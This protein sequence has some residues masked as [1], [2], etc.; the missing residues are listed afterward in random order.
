M[1]GSMNSYVAEGTNSFPTIILSKSEGVF[2]VK[3]RSTPDNAKE[4]FEPALEW[5]NNY[6]KSP[7]LETEFVFD[8][9]FFNISSS[10]VILFI[11]YKLLELQ[12]AGHKVKVTWCYSDAYLLGAGRDYAYM[13]KIP[14]TFKKVPRKESAT[15]DVA[16]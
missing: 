7:N 16:A 1:S 5:L 13:V 14:F 8:L 11:L 3:G 2:L 12:T 10:K 4:F 15:K 6:A 9:D